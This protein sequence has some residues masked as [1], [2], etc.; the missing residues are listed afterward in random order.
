MEWL[1]GGFSPVQLWLNYLAFVPLPAII[2]GLYAIQRPRIAHLGLF[3]A[4]RYGFSFVYFTHTTL[5]ALALQTP[6]YA[7]FWAHLAWVYT[8]HGALMIMG[9]ACFGWATARAGVLPQWTAWLFLSGLALNLVLGMLPVPDLRQIIGTTFRNA[10]LVGMGW[11]A[12]RRPVPNN[13]ERPET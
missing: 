8:A 5:L 3:G 7:Q 13:V 2:T 6:T 12:S 9:G 11:S 10:G 4:L 1:Q